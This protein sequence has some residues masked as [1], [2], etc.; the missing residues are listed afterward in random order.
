MPDG[1]P[2]ECQLDCNGNLIPDDLDISGGAS[3]DCNGNGIPDECEID[4][5]SPAPGGPFFCMVNCDPDCNENGIPDECDIVDCPPETPACDDCNLNGVPDECDIA[6]GGSDDGNGDGVPDECIEATGAGDWSG[7]IWGLGGDYPDNDPKN[8]SGVPDLSVT[9]DGE[10]L[11]VFADVTVEI[12]S[13]RLLNA[14]SLAV[15]QDGEQGDLTIFDPNGVFDGNLLIQGT[16]NIGGERVID[17]AG[18]VTI[19]TGGVYKSIFGFEVP[20]S[21]DLLADEIVVRCGGSLRLEGTMHLGTEGNIILQD[22]EDDD[23]G[24]CTPPDFEGGD[25]SNAAVGGDFKI[26]GPANIDYNSTQPLLLGGDFDN[27]STDAEIFDWSTGG[28]LLNGPLH[29]IEAAGED[30][31]RWP[32]GLVDNFAIGTLTLAAETTVQVVDTFD[33]QQDGSAACDETLYVDTC[34]L[35][36][37]AILLTNGCRVYYNELFNDGSIPGLGVDVL[38]IL[39]PVP[40]DFNGDGVVDAFDL[41]TLLGHWGDCPEPCA[42]GDPADTCATD[43]NGDCVTEAFDLAMLLGSWGPA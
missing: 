4:E 3:P 5:N 41:A 1:I 22:S 16:L 14:A 29:T 36:T 38:E 19:G 40:A 30:R 33:N 37:G 10:D 43:L 26:Q 31:G 15:T 25:D 23:K 18:T 21:G 20:N 12:P 11:A 28:I 17:A 9:L 32:A 42:P 2:D 8:P 7:D 27:H 6:R 39:E 24:D 35:E 34:V 13:L